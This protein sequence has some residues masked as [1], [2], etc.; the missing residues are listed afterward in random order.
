MAVTN[1]FEGQYGPAHTWNG[2][3]PPTSGSAAAYGGG[4][5]T[6]QTCDDFGNARTLNTWFWADDVAS[7]PVTK[8]VPTCI[9]GG[10]MSMFDDIDDDDDG[11]PDLVECGGVDPNAD[12]D[13]DTIPN[14]LDPSYPGFVDV[15]Y[16]GINDHFDADLDGVINSLD[17]D[18]DNDGIYDITEAGGTDSDH[19]GMVDSYVDDNNNGLT[20]QYDPAC[21]GGT[22]TYYG[23]SYTT[24]G[25]VTDPA[26]AID[27]NLNSYAVL[28]NTSSNGVINIALAHTLTTGTQVTVR[29]QNN[30][31]NGNLLVSC[32]SNGTTYSSTTQFNTT[33]T[34]TNNTYTLPQNAS[35]IRV[36]RNSYDSKLFEIFY[37]YTNCSGGIAISNPDTDGDG[38]H[39]FLNMDSDNDGIADIVEAGGVDTEGNGR[40]ENFT[41]ANNNGISDQ[42]DYNCSGTSSTYSGQSVASQ[43]GVTNSTYAL[44]VADGIGAQIY[45]NTDIL[46]IDMGSSIPS[47]T[48]VSLRW[49]VSNG[50][51]G[52]AIMNIWADNNSTPTTVQSCPTTASTFYVTSTITLNTDARYFRIRKGQ[53]SCG[54]GSSS[55]DFDLDAITATVSPVCTGGDLIS[56]FDTDGDGIVNRLDLDSDDDGIPDVVE[57]GG[58]DANNDGIIDS[59]SDSDGDGFATS[60]D[61]DANG[62]G[63]S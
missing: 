5:S 53:N 42:Y 24:S 29:S 58:T 39:N 48:T 54:T 52:T 22:A 41:D 1:L 59:Y 3:N 31:T 45:E 60:V 46:I 57:A 13:N 20:D 6:T 11:I 43:T 12:A 37:T 50:G 23:V 18:S 4:S 16:D 10:G 36:A 28:D 7:T 33:G 9:S 17:L 34:I 40:V 2:P 15:N 14:Y 55:T 47:G 63:T 61:G 25:T 26:K 62:D 19:D 38:V 49:R 27:E 51:T 30:G 8:S 44:G 35:Y 21:T 56:D 32:S